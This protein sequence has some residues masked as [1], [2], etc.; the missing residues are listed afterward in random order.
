[1]CEILLPSN[2]PTLSKTYLEAIQRALR[3][4]QCR[5]IP[6][7]GIFLR[8]LYAIVNDVPNVVVI[9]HQD[10]D[11]KLEFTYDSNGEDHF[12]SKIGVGG[13]LNVDKINLIAVV[14][15][16]LELFHRHNQ[17]L[18]KYI[19]EQN[20]SPNASKDQKEIKGY[21]PVQ[22]IF[23][24]TRGVTLIPL[25]TMNFDLDTIQRL[26]HGTT[27]IR[28]DPDSGRSVIC[29]L[30]LDSS[31]SFISWYKVG[32]ISNNKEGKEKVSYH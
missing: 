5:L 29:L 11:Q 26:H 24:A 21:E 30:R 2:Q 7:F 13:L 25:T 1:L 23:D 3:M 8:D 16:N 32:Y 19:D 6:F 28:Y 22:P 18:S 31:C 4:P 9:G 27:V 12:S 20:C 14:L 15:D 17:I 10:E